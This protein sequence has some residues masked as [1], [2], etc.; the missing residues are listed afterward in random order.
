MDKH[1]KQQVQP[2]SKSESE[3]LKIVGEYTLTQLKDLL[4][5]T[6]IE[7]KEDINVKL[8]EPWVLKLG[9]V[10]DTHLNNKQCDIDSL[11]KFYEDADKEWVDAFV[12]AGDMTDWIN[13]YKGQIYELMNLSFDDQLRY[14][15]EHY[16]KIEW[17]DT[18]WISWNHDESRL[19]Q[20][21]ISF[22]DALSK[23]RA[24]MKHL[25]FYNA[26]VKLNGFDVEL[27]HWW[28][29]SPY[30][31][32]YH[33]QRYMER[34]PQEEHLDLW[35]LWHYHRE[36][37]MLYRWAL[38]M[39]PWAF[40]KENLL[41]KRFKLGNN[42]SGSVVELKRDEQGKLEFLSHLYKYR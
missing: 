12:H 20:W 41:A 23:E 31:A 25:W 17:K 40:L 5:Q 26:R 28:W 15:E 33:L 34:I 32:S 9:I 14:V 2:L 1:E 37:S 42:I 6:H 27:Q 8:W 3:K 38:A 7:H 22:G 29:S 11:H 19:K 35:V 39:L 36:L 10:S 30:A 18:Y 16:P 13:V 24:D 21:G 4:S